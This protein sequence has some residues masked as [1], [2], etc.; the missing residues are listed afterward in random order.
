M[1]H[2]IIGRKARIVAAAALA[3]GLVSPAPAA[4]V[5]FEFGGFVTDVT[6][7]LGILNGLV[8]NGKNTRFVGGVTW[9]TATP[10]SAPAAN[11]GQYNGT[12]TQFWVKFDNGLLFTQGGPQTYNNVSIGNDRTDFESPIFD[13][14]YAY[15]N[16]DSTP[17]GGGTTDLSIGLQ[18][19][20]PSALTDDKLPSSLDAT[21]FLDPDGLLGMQIDPDF[22]FGFV[23]K[24]V[25]YL[26]FHLYQ[27]GGSTDLYGLLDKGGTVPEPTPLALALVG[28]AALG[29]RRAPARRQVGAD[30]GGP[31]AG[32]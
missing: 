32:Q 9:D 29:L 20:D 19:T 16:W 21:K 26:E 15:A 5:T 10:D 23:D 2:R 3:L 28:F 8:P 22:F 25:A 14:F 24:Q 17:Y 6:D 12:V 11:F 7:D 30:L 13:G 1:H 4:P 31:P 27:D 18:S